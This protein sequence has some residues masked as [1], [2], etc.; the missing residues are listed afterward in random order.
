VLAS[1]V[2][3]IVSHRLEYDICARSF[4]LNILTS[5]SSL[6]PS[7]QVNVEVVST[8]DTHVAL[9]ESIFDFPAIKTLLDRPDFTMVYDSMHGVNGPY[10]RKV[11][12][13][14]FGLSEDT[15]INSVP[16][17]DFNG[18]HADPNLTYAKELVAVC[19]LDKKGLKI[20]MAGKR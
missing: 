10:A 9:L 3:N 17:D 6:R 7:L 12:C 20:D 16:K 13:E 1:H 14:G 19:G 5:N 15:M 11:F 8:G 18:G 4:N 2:I